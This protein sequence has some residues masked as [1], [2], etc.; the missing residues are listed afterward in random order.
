MEFAG[1]EIDIRHAQ[2]QDFVLAAAG[3]HQQADRRHGRHRSG[4]AVDRLV[5]HLPQPGAGAEV[6]AAVAHQHANGTG[7]L[8]E[9]R[10]A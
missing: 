6:L 3:E 8:L 4:A 9:A 10:S 7:S 2:G 5:Q 1:V